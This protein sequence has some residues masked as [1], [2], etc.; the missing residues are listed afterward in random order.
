MALGPTQPAIQWVP[1]VLSLGVKRPWREADHS[2]PPSAE[3]KE[4]VE[5]YLHSPNTHSWLGAQLK[6]RHNLT[7]TLPYLT[8][9]YLTLPLLSF[10]EYCFNI[11][12]DKSLSTSVLD[13]NFAGNKFRFLSDTNLCNIHPATKVSIQT[14]TDALSVETAIQMAEKLKKSLCAYVNITPWNCSE[15]DA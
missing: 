13:M 15:R 12:K 8:L 11:S 7:F 2:S 1:G 3:V 5:L 10:E 6:H 9:P 4:W 14:N